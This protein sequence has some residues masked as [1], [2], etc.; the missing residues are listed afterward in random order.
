MSGSALS[1][2]V[3]LVL[4]ASAPWETPAP[5]NVHQIARRMA[6]RG[7]QVLFVESTGLR[8]PSLGSGHDWRRVA[9]RLK[10]ARR[11]LREVAP[12]LWVHSPLALPG[13]AAPRLRALSDRLLGRSVV[14]VA[15]RLGLQAPVVW[16]FLPTW[17]AVARA[18]GGRLLVYHCV[19][20]YA[21]NPGVDAARVDAA[22]RAMLRGA[23][24]VFASSPVLAERLG[25]TRPDV[26]LLPNVA[27]VELFARARGGA[28]AEPAELAGVPRPRA[29]YAGNLA[30]YRVDLPLLSGLARARRDIQWLFVGAVGLGDPRGA[31]AGWGALAAEPNVQAFG[32]RPQDEL[33]A[34]LAHVDV[35]LIPF[36]DNAHTRASLPLKLW[37]YLA[38]GV[39]VVATALPNLEPL[40]EQGLVHVA[41][42]ADGFARALDAALADGPDAA[43]GR[44]R[45]ARAHDWCARI[46]ELATLLAARPGD[47]GAVR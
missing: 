31:P 20:H 24:R 41:R 43:E 38:A 4:L 8:A 42:G 40:A 36:L 3:P 1:P 26:V 46:D 11:P 32:P 44:A 15:R 16:A 33:P 29:L 10:R 23:D 14:R 34:W 47:P 30:G 19:D 7:H 18:V 9:Q 27:D 45:A 2:D 21:G 13:G 5:V 6:A 39:P 25:K 37:E 22:E 17:L 35:A 28:L 12:R